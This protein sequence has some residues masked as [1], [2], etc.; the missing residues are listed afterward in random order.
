[1]KEYE[2]YNSG[3]LENGIENDN[4]IDINFNESEISEE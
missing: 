4:L 3:S 2:L 1:M